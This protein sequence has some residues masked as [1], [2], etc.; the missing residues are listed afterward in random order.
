MKQ[1]KNG[2]ALNPRGKLVIC[3]LYKQLSKELEQ[4]IRHRM[5]NQFPNADVIMH[6]DVAEL[7]ASLTQSSSP[8]SPSNIIVVT[9]LIKKTKAEK[10]L[11]ILML[12]V[13]LKNAKQSMYTYS[14]Y[15]SPLVQGAPEQTTWCLNEHID[16][17]V[18]NLSPC[19]TKHDDLT[20]AVSEIIKSGRRIAHHPIYTEDEIAA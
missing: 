18:V 20:S 9:D 5:L 7:R 19:P 11:S 8:S 16:T 12:E 3:L 15:Y 10:N 13:A 1:V 14:I 2:V 17:H 4:S 6:K